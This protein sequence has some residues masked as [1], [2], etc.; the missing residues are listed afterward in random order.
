M[1]LL[2]YSGFLNKNKRLLHQK[3]TRPDA[4]QKKVASVTPSKLYVILHCALKIKAKNVQ[5]D[6]TRSIFAIAY[7][8]NIVY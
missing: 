7:K 1:P 4:I 5:V 8:L 2:N 6:R 3:M